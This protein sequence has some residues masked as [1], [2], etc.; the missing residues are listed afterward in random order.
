M[1]ARLL[2]DQLLSPMNDRP[3]IEARLDAVAELVKDHA[4]R[5]DLRLLFKDTADLTR[6]TARAATQRATPKD[7]AAVVRTLALMPK[8][9]A[10]LAGRTATVHKQLDAALDLCPELRDLL[11]RALA[12]D[13]PYQI[14]DGGA[15][16]P[17]FHEELD[18][19][20][21]LATDG[22]TWMA[23]Y[24]A[25]Q[26]EASGIPSL[27]VS[28]TQA[29]GYYIEITNAHEH[30][31]PATY[32]H[33]RTLKGAKRYT[34]PELREY[35]EQV[36]TAEDRARGLEAELFAGL[37][38]QVATAAPRLIAAAEALA[39]LDMLAGLAELAVSR[40]YVRPAIV[41]E[42]I[43]DLRDGRHPVLDQTLPAGQFVPND[44]KFGDEPG[45]FWLITGPNMSG[46]STFIRQVAL[47]ALLAHVGSFVPCS[48]AVV[49]LTDRIFTRVGASDELSRGQST[50]MVEMTEAAN[51]LNNATGQSL[52]ILDEIGRGTSTY[53]G[54]SLA[55]AIAEHLHT[56]VGSRTLFATH[57]HELADLAETLPG[58]RN[59]NVE[60][61]EAGGE[62]VFLHKIAP[63]RAD[64]SY[65][66]HVAKLAGV[67]E[68]VLARAAIVLEGLERRHAAAPPPAAKPLDNRKRK[69]RFSGPSLFAE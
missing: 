48:S 10:K 26:A 18:R 31:V 5:T 50:F 65:G 28:F 69:P 2:H 41:D 15:I 39:M 42:P 34:T 19:L 11:T 38:E 68:P 9:K 27:K 49:G 66:I 46:K 13:P 6:L 30:R 52:V 37:R 16:R 14:K 21:Q 24:Q 45:I 32:I 8:L 43:L 61:R 29:I 55:W 67:P 57:Y 62:V 56:D 60:V 20:R 58:L 4:F 63:G 23:R 7:L 33:E 53:D 35:Q 17:G 3:A 44:V 1:G 22:K 54:V 12:D 64:Q 59:H 25:A 47:I 51:I 36:L 40:N